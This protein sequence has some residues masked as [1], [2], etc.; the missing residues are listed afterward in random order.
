MEGKR[1]FCDTAGR[2]HVLSVN[3]WT[4]KRIREETGLDIMD[5]G[6]GGQAADQLVAK[7]IGD[8]I[9]LVEVIWTAI[10]P[11]AEA[12]GIEKA[13]FFA[14]MSGDAIDQATSAFLEGLADF[15]PSPRDR[16]RAHRILQGVERMIERAQDVM[17]QK[18]EGGELERILEAEMA[19]I[20]GGTS[21][22]S[23][24]PSAPTP[25]R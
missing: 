14:S 6:A 13:A 2:E 18:V 4:L 15:F 1:T 24:A 7:L 12:A 21:I 23:P 5:L 10:R 17:D 11:E 9:T 22:N 20:C 25:A 19:A 8:P 16:A 3:T